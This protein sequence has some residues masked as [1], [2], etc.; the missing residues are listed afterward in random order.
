MDV[1]LLAWVMDSDNQGVLKERQ[2]KATKVGQNDT[3]DLD[4]PNIQLMSLNYKAV[5]GIVG[6]DVLN[7][8]DV[9]NNKNPESYLELLL[10][11]LKQMHVWN[12]IR[13]NYR[14]L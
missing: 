1:Q 13:F 2:H 8:K 6:D 10:Q 12:L 9:W 3:P 11:R 5:S 4:S 14:V 7:P